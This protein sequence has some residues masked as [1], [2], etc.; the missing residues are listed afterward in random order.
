MKHIEAT[1]DWH[2]GH[3]VGLT[4]PQ[5]WQHEKS[6]HGKD[7]RTIWN[8]W[9]SMRKNVPRPDL[10]I[11]NGD[12]IDG[13]G[14]KSG[15]TEQITTDREEQCDMAEEI[16]KIIN[17]KS[18]RMTYGTGYHTGN[19]EDWEHVLAKRIGADDIGSNLWIDAVIYWSKTGT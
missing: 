17:P 6:L 2:C 3:V 4:P 18:V 11:I 19:H 9:Q 16:I 12:A 7:Q 14:D 15:G 10:L 13:R 8:A 5:W 1:G